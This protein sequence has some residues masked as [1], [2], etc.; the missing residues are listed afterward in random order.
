MRRQD[1]PSIIEKFWRIVC[2]LTQYLQLLLIGFIILILLSLFALMF[3][4]SGTASYVILQVDLG[5]NV[6]AFLSIVFIL[7][8]C[9]RRRQK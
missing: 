1:D 2:D 9:G 5:L 6:V 4:E 7:H 3:G 8:R